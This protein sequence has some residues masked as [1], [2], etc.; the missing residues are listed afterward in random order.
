M[1]GFVREEEVASPLIPGIH[2]RVSLWLGLAQS[3]NNKSDWLIPE[4]CMCA[5]SIIPT[6]AKKCTISPVS[7]DGSRRLSHTSFTCIWEPNDPF[8]R[9]NEPQH[10]KTNKIAYA[11]SETPIS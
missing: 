1:A 5:F 7:G 2:T 3:C 8:H 11:P 9:Q 10:Y 6:D 4:E